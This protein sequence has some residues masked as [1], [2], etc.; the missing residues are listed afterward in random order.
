MYNLT[1]MYNNHIEYIRVLGRTYFSGVLDFQ[2]KIFMSPNEFLGVPRGPEHISP[3][4]H[5]MFVT[6]SA[7]GVDV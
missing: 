2:G 7:L 5:V 4:I 3:F 6:P 1:V